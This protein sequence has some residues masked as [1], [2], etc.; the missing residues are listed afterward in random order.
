[1]SDVED[2]VIQLGQMPV[3]PQLATIDGAMLADVAAAR[4]GDLRRPI[5]FATI[6]ALVVGMAG[7]GLPTEPA[8]AQGSLTPF[9]AN[10]PLM[11]STLLG[12]TP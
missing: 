2:L 11:P 8:S 3:P 5:A 9:A 7:A 6:F 4:A 1:M 12:Q 10:S